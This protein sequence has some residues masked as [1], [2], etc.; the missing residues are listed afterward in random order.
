MCIHVQ[1]LGVLMSGCLNVWVSKC[2]G[3]IHVQCLGVLV[4]GCL[5]VQVYTCPVYWC[6]NVWVSKCPGVWMSKYG[7][8][9]SN[10]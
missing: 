6:L 9:M 2:P 3:D 10:G 4:C 7:E 5:N 1:C 8:Q